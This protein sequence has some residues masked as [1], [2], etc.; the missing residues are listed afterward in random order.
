[1]AADDGG[2]KW[3]RGL[4]CHRVERAAAVMAVVSEIWMQEVQELSGTARSW[5]WAH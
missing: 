4:C 1:M 2:S 3:K 5:V